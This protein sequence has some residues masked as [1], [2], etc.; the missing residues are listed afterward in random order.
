MQPRRRSIIRAP[1]NAKPHPSENL[2]VTP[3]SL[4]QSVETFAYLTQ[5]LT[6]AD[7]DRAWAWGDYESEG[8]RFAFFRVYEE[9]RT[10][11]VQAGSSP[12]VERSFPLLSPA[13]P[14]PLPR[15]LPRPTSC[16]VGCAGRAV[17]L[18]A[19]RGRVAHSTGTETYRERRCRVLCSD[20]P[21]L[22]PAPQRRNPARRSH[23]SGLR[24]HPRHR[25]GAGRG[26]PH[27][28]ARVRFRHFTPRSI[29]VFCASWLESASRRSICRR[30]S[31]KATP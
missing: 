7:L 29:D 11:A 3:T 8:V 13:H 6:D 16:A 2:T 31:G 18:S 20:Y 22:E 5:S 14:R 27:R 21:R 4:A 15:C 23:T 17:R 19:S 30:F 24:C 1:T 10:L 26:D 25:R 28:A 9:L 12:R